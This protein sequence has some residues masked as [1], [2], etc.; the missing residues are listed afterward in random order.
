MNWESLLEYMY[1]TW[2]IKNGLK[3]GDDTD[4]EDDKK[5][6]ALGSV[7]FKGKCH[8]CGLV[9]HKKHHCPNGK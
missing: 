4:L 5:E 1:V 3:E 6:V 7:T 2:R 9:G 8:G